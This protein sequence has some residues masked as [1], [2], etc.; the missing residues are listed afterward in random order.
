[1]IYSKRVTVSILNVL[2][3]TTICLS[4]RPAS[5]EG[6]RLIDHTIWCEDTKGGSAKANDNGKTGTVSCFVN[7]KSIHKAIKYVVATGKLEP[8]HC[9]CDSNGNGERDAGDELKDEDGNKVA[10]II[11]SFLTLSIPKMDYL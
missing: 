10:D 3:L 8:E 2:V 4:T 11:L 6:A 5:A 9:L 1:M 7:G